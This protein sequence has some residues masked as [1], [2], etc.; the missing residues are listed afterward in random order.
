LQSLEDIVVKNKEHYFANSVFLKKYIYN[1][2]KIF[3][4]YIDCTWWWWFHCNHSWTHCHFFSSLFLLSHFPNLGSFLSFLVF[5]KWLSLSFSLSPS[6]S[7]SHS[8]SVLVW[9]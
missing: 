3:L 8:L 5:Y 6:L 9:I 1:H 7:L 2:Y 4:A